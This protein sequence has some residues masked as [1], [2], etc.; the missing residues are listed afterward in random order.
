MIGIE[1][2]WISVDTSAFPDGSN[3]WRGSNVDHAIVYCRNNPEHQ[4]RRTHKHIRCCSENKIKRKSIFIFLLSKKHQM[5]LVSYYSGFSF[6]QQSIIFTPVY[7]NV[8][9]RFCVVCAAIYFLT[10]QLWM[11]TVRLLLHKKIPTTIWRH[12]T[13]PIFVRIIQCSN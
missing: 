1:M 3:I 9:V 10:Q 5:T 8:I 6:G 12:R 2:T 7:M 4:H 11:L 13:K